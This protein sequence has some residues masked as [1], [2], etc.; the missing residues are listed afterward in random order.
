MTESHKKIEERKKLK[1]RIG[2]AKEK[3]QYNNY[4]VAQLVKRVQRD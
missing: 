4:S 3:G 2:E 1:R